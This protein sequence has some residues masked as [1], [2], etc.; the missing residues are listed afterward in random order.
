M[1][2]I[3]KDNSKTNVYL[4]I[5]IL[6]GSALYNLAFFASLQFIVGTADFEMLNY[7]FL[8]AFIG[9]ILFFVFQRLLFQKLFFTTLIAYNAFPVLVLLLASLST[10]GIFVMTFIFILTCILAFYN[11]KMLN[12]QYKIVPIIFFTACICLTVYLPSIS[13]NYLLMGKKPPKTAHL[14]GKTITYNFKTLDGQNISSDSLKDKVV[15]IECWATWCKPC[16]ALLPQYQNVYNKYEKN[17]H[18][19]FLSTNIDN[20]EDVKKIKNFI[21]KRNLK[22]PIYRDSI[23]KFL[24]ELKINSIPTTLIL[25]NNIVKAVIV[26]NNTENDYETEVDDVIKGLIKN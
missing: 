6:L 12:R 15:L 7:L 9:N 20:K 21:E 18:I 11:V 1:K 8:F 17:P 5:F 14:M 10:F 2:T 25:K 19:A 13:N 26:G 4:F 3:M 22:F 16:I 23:G 24:S